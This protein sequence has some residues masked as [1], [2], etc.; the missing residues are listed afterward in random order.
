MAAVF[1]HEMAHALV[2]VILGWQCHYISIGPIKVKHQEDGTWRTGLVKSPYLWGG[3]IAVTPKS[4]YMVHKE[5]LI[6]VIVAGPA[7]SLLSAMILFITPLPNSYALL[8]LAFGLITAMP[9]RR[10]NVYSDGGKIQQLLKNEQTAEIELSIIRIGVQVFKYGNF[11]HVFTEDIEV[12]MKAADIRDSYRGT[13]YMWCRYKDIGQ[14]DKADKVKVK[15][16]E[17]SILLPI[18]LKK[19]LRKLT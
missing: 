2:G 4:T 18:S 13:Y 3:A 7:A 19:R 8:F 16:D 6:K 14:E 15:L 12:L 17:L 1:V 5:Q 11:S 10:G 9:Y